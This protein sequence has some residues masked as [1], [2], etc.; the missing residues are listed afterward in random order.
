MSRRMEAPQRRAIELTVPL[1]GAALVIL[2]V[3]AAGRGSVVPFLAGVVAG[4]LVA[5]LL[6]AAQRLSRS[7]PAPPAESA[8]AAVEP[9]AK[10][11]R[12]GRHHES[13]Y[14]YLAEAGEGLIWTH[15]LDG[16][17]LSVNPAAAG[18]LGWEAADLVGRPV[19]ELLVEPERGEV[20]WP[21]AGPTEPGQRL[22]LRLRTRSGGRR[23]WSMSKIHWQDDGAACVLGHGLDITR[24]KEAEAEL[25]Q[26]RDEAVESARLKSEFLANMSHEIR[27]PM[28]GVLGMADVLLDTQLSI[29]QREYAETIR[30]SADALLTVVNDILDFSKVEA[31]ALVFEDLDF[32][33]RPLVESSVDLFAEAAKRKRIDLATLVF[34]DV[35]DAMRGDPGRLRQVITNLVGNAIKFTEEGEVTVRVTLEAQTEHQVVLRFSIT[36]TGIGIALAAQPNLFQAFVQGDGSTSRRYGGTGLGLAISKQLVERMHGTIGVESETGR[37]STFWF[38]ARFEKQQAATAAGPAIVSLEGRRI[39][40][41]DDNATNRTILAH[42]ATAWGMLPEQ[43]AGGEEALYRLRSAAALG[44]P[45][46]VAILDL[47]MPGM[48]GFEL[49]RFVKSDPL[50][51]GA[52]LILMPSFGKRGHAMDAREAGIAAYLVKPVKQ[53]EVEACLTAVFRD[54]GDG[55]QAHPRLVTRHTLAEASGFAAPRILIAEDNP[56]NQK[57]LMAQVSKLGYRADIVTDGRA[58]L[59]ALARSRYALVLMDVHMPGMDGYEATRELRR[60]EGELFRTPVI[61]VTASVTA[62]EREN[63]LNAGMDDYLTKP[64]RQRDLAAMLQKWLPGDMAAP[65]AWEP[66]PVPT[67]RL[68]R[69]LARRAAGD[70]SLPVP[71]A[72]ERGRSSVGSP[73]GLPAAVQVGSLALVDS[74]AAAAVHARLHELRTECGEEIVGEFVTEFLRDAAERMA[75]LRA[76]LEARDAGTIE[77]EAHALKGGAA[78]LGGD[79]LAE[80]CLVLEE[81]GEVGDFR[82]TAAVFGQI[83]TELEQLEATLR[84]AYPGA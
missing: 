26:A 83:E 4:L 71:G 17:L 41:V 24:W 65:G 61:A 58:A 54:N 69:A 9:A 25:Q 34:S 22:E 50:T 10:R 78:N 33:L 76:A 39:L 52:R 56:V 62:G 67:Q 47:M 57:V 40:I 82:G 60:Q 46:D 19:T 77:A 1:V 75:R 53:S 64:T 80:W 5:V 55:D 6:R 12:R 59:E 27:T 32:S 63:C 20:W 66:M 2:A 23:V 11:D 70:E 3:V 81:K 45:F 31:G 43:V 30:A 79:R 28:N 21:A 37:G 51:A 48:T 73:E 72:G 16:T 35:P 29:E 68:D 13:R 38:T 44:K 36:D 15:D 7:E 14:R 49:A 8:A 74:R 18:A 42:Y 84:G